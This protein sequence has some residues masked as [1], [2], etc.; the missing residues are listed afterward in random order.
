MTRNIANSIVWLAM[1]ALTAY[2]CYHAF[3]FS[4]AVSQTLRMG[5]GVVTDCRVTE[6]THRVKHSR[7]GP[8][9]IISINFEY[10]FRGTVYRQSSKRLGIWGTSK[11]AIERASEAYD[12]RSATY[13]T[14]DPRNPAEAVLEIDTS[15]SGITVRLL[16][17]ALIFS[18]PALLTWK[19]RSMRPAITG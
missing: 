11:S 3:D 4:L 9:T 18:F 12:S 1:V 2:G 15:L 10:D 6:F 14:V 17:M 19:R 5:K 16:K 7:K 13:C 8:S